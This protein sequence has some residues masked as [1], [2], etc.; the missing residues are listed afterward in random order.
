MVNVEERDGIT[1]TY[2]DDGWKRPAVIAGILL[3]AVGMVAYV[4]DKLKDPVATAILFV[5]FAFTAVFSFLL[6]RGTQRQEHVETSR[7]EDSAYDRGR[8]DLAQNAMASMQISMQMMRMMQQ[9]QQTMAFGQLQPPAQPAPQVPQLT[10]APRFERTGE[11]S[12]APSDLIVRDAN[13]LRKLHMDGHKVTRAT[14]ERM[15]GIT[16][17]VR[18]QN[19][20]NK[21]IRW[22]YVREMG[23]GKAPA[24]DDD[25]QP[26]P[27]E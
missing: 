1:T 22:G 13:A 14:A 5:L 19:A 7:A 17:G 6:G 4:V 2:T 21:L 8:D 25:G 23:Q 16:D 3:F 10:D 20:V 18:Y 12:Y 24:W 15:L 26:S 11:N 27:A 9:A